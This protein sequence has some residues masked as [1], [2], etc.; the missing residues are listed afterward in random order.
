MVASAQTQSVHSA[1]SLKW[2]ILL[3]RP[4]RLIVLIALM[5]SLG[6][7]MRSSLAQ[8]APEVSLPLDDVPRAMSLP[9]D[10]VYLYG[11]APE[12]GQIG[13]DYMVFELHHQEIVG[14]LYRPH[15]SFDC[16]QGQVSEAALTLS[17]TNS[18][19]LETYPYDIAL[20]SNDTVATTGQVG[21]SLQL[22]GFHRLYSLSNLDV[23]L[24]NTCKAALSGPVQR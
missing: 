7:L 23:S 9:R 19:T 15:S 8:A 1:P 3:G 12:P 16:F 2:G 13:V 20:I 18:Y 17:I 22:D 14:A 10:G 6:S 11:Q 4:F 21:S 24:L 5:A